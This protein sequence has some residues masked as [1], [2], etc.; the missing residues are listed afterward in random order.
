MSSL[1]RFRR[2]L[3]LVPYLLAHPGTTIAELARRHDTTE[4]T[5]LHDLANLEW[6][7]LP[8]ALGDVYIDVEVDSEQRVTLGVPME[9][10]TP[11]RLTDDE[12]LRLLLAVE[13]ID[14]AFGSDGDALSRAV[15][16][17]R[18]AAGLSGRLLTEGDTEPSKAHLDAID[19]ALREGR[20]VRLRYQG[21]ADEEPRDRHVDPWRLTRAGWWYVQGHDEL[22]DALR[23]FRLDRCLEVEVLS[24]PLRHP[25]PDDLPPPRYEPGPDDVEVELVVPHRAAWVLGHVD[26]SAQDVR[27]DRT[28]HA[29]FKTDALDW[30]AR[31]LTSTGVPV[32]V[33]APESLRH[34]MRSIARRGLARNGSSPL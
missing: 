20:R 26:L 34:R 4:A 31:L 29:R 9:A 13:S 16:K 15:V 11:L 28:V 14:G 8:G 10:P 32:E 23:S 5:I 17:V 33:L 30:V 27:S 19:R 1:E 18:R 22:R 24:E 3:V 21:R 25:A 6:C 2:M 12:A 7:G